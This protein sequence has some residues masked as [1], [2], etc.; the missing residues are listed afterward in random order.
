MTRNQ[1]SGAEL[2]ERCGLNKLATIVWTWN[3]E[4]Q[5]LFQELRARLENLFH[6]AV[7]ILPRCGLRTARAFAGSGF[8]GARPRLL[9][10]FESYLKE[11]NSGGKNAPELHQNPV[12][13]FSASSFPRVAA[14]SAGGL[15]SFGHHT[16]PRA[17]S[18]S[19]LWDQP[20]LPRGL[21]PAAIDTN[22]WQT[23]FYNLIQSAERAA[24]A[25][26]EREGERLIC[27]VEVNMETWRSRHG[28]ST[29]ARAV[30]L[31]DTNLP[32]TTSISAASRRG[33]MAATAPAHHAGTSAR[34][35]RRAAAGAR[36]ASS[37]VFH[38]TKPRGVSHAGADAREDAGS[39]NMPSAGRDEGALHFTTHT[40]WRPERPL[41]AP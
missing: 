19:A 20:V 35:R 4:A 15:A 24:G 27:N 6:N 32:K 29:S 36:S 34:R 33:C 30:Y 23:E 13:Y 28:A 37:L 17:T 16:N 31:I 8:P 12:A 14:I 5:D 7:A 38:R 39:R 40:R 21:F 22:N 3:Q 18:I 26:A 25:G 10:N 11:T 1:L 9:Q 41:F 2:N